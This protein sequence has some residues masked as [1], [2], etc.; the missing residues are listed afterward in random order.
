VEVLRILI[1]QCEHHLPHHHPFTI[2]SY[3]DLAAVLLNIN[4]ESS[5]LKFINRARNHLNLYLTD[6]EDYCRSHHQ[7]VD[8]NDSE[9]HDFSLPEERPLD[10]LTIFEANICEMRSYMERS[11]LKVLS[12]DHPIFL[13][14]LC[15]VADALV[16]LATCE[17]LIYKT[18]Q[19]S[20]AFSL[21]D[22]SWMLAGE[23]YRQALIGWIRSFGVIHPNVPAAACGLAR[24]LHKT[25]Q[26]SEAMELLTSV[27][28]AIQ[29]IYQDRSTTRNAIDPG[30]KSASHQAVAHCLWMLATYSSENSN[31]IEGRRQVLRYLHAASKELRMVDS[32]HMNET[33]LKSSVEMLLTIEHEAKLIFGMRE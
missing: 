25:R 28:D 19:T 31:S 5:A 26:T 17:E 23:H 33:E 29:D 10:V 14:S 18:T 20:S 32:E 30:M 7:N 4:D 9:T 24:C 16:V 3:L 21:S 8:P 22:E 6:Q 1:I 11:M 12:S 13:L 2:A 15:F 27:I